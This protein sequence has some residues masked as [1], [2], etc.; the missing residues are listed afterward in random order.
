MDDEHQS[1]YFSGFSFTKGPSKRSRSSE[2]VVSPYDISYYSC[3]LNFVTVQ[4]STVTA[5]GTHDVTPTTDSE[6]TKTTISLPTIAGSTGVPYAEDAL[7]V[8]YSLLN[9]CEVRFV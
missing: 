4:V 3:W 5:T 2:A 8:A 6:A 7:A 1:G 9:A